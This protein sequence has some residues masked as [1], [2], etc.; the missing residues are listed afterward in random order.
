MCCAVD[1]EYSGTHYERSHLPKHHITQHHHNIRG[2][3]EYIFFCR[4]C[5]RMRLNGCADEAGGVVWGEGL[6]GMG[7][8]GDNSGWNECVL[9]LGND[10]SWCGFAIVREWMYVCEGLVYRFWKRILFV[11]IIII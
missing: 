9:G 7:R 4:C 6:A 1:V 10:G 11:R 3:G 2:G 8:Q 5:V